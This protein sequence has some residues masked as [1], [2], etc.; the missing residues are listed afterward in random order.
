MPEA[1]IEFYV[2]ASKNLWVSKKQSSSAS[3]I[4]SSKKIGHAGC[5]GASCWHQ[6]SRMGN[7]LHENVISLMD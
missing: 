1:N 6:W 5:L 3:L 7:T 4:A 2:I